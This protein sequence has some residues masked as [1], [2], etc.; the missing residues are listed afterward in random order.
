MT[1]DDQPNDLEVKTALCLSGGG[2]RSAA[3][4]IGVLQGL[5]GSG[6]K[7]GEEFR[8]L[9]TVSGGGF[10]GAW[11][12][13]KQPR[14]KKSFDDA[15]GELRG[16]VA[17]LDEAPSLKRWHL[18]R[19]RLTG[20]LGIGSA[21][22]AKLLVFWLFAIP[23]LWTVLLVLEQI[24]ELIDPVA[25]AAAQLPNWSWLATAVLAIAVLQVELLRTVAVRVGL[26]VA[27]IAAVHY[28][29]SF[30]AERIQ[31]ELLALGVALGGG[32]VALGRSA[33]VAQLRWV[34]KGIGT[35]RLLGAIA[36]ASLALVVVVAALALVACRERLSSIADALP[37]VREV[38]EPWSIAI[39]TAIPVVAL[40]VVR[41]E[42]FL[43]ARTYQERIRAG[44][45]LGHSRLPSLSQR[46][47]L[48]LVRGLLESI[49]PSWIKTRV[50]SEPVTDTEGVPKPTLLV[51]TAWSI[52]EKAERQWDERKARSFVWAFHRR[53]EPGCYESRGRE[54]VRRGRP[55]VDIAVAVATSAGVV[56]PRMGSYTIRPLGLLFSMFNVRLGRWFKAPDFGSPTG[57]LGGLVL[58]ELF[59]GWFR[60]QPDPKDLE[61]SDRNKAASARRWM[62]LT[63]GG[64]FDNLGLY[65]AVK[66]KCTHVIV[67]DGGR[68]PKYRF[69]ELANALRKIRIDHEQTE[70]DIDGLRWTEAGVEQTGHRRQRIYGGTIRY[71]GKT[72]FG[73]IVYIKAALEGDEPADV[74]GYAD[75]HPAFPHE[76][77]SD[78]W[79]S[80]SQFESYR[81]LGAYTVE[82]ALEHYAAAK[83]V[84]PLPKE[85]T[86]T[87]AKAVVERLREAAMIAGR[88]DLRPTHGGAIVYR[89]QDNTNKLEFLF[90]EA[91]GRGSWV[92]PKGHIEC[93]E[94]PFQCARRELEEEAE[95]RWDDRPKALPRALVYDKFKRGSDEEVRC[96]YHLVDLRLLRRRKQ[97]NGEAWESAE[98]GRTAAEVTSATASRPESSSDRAAREE[99]GQLWITAEDYKDVLEEFERRL[100][101]PNSAFK[102]S[103]EEPEEH[104]DASW[105]PE[106]K[107]PPDDPEAIATL[108]TAREPIEGLVWVLQEAKR[109]VE[110][111]EQQ[112]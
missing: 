75:L 32:V 37:L 103:K 35:M 2:V 8:Y 16:T 14:D 98:D 91:L 79:F 105:E 9:S 19:W 11:Y 42:Y 39:L 52:D 3:F 81:R 13:T 111:A 26:L 88:A 4:S 68:D 110:L 107:R 85:E 50:E 65:E 92:L 66:R 112:F 61:G 83:L 55:T 15:L 108:L 99:R 10:A 70:I 80:E 21:F 59:P 33:Q 67:V 96:L 56:G 5:R 47:S 100:K 51:N 109:R 95:L 17:Y 60:P 62:H 20:A 45:K 71:P 12:W 57:S 77:T 63:D 18:D 74:A 40:G 93:G 82:A 90:V 58:E 84:P 101:N 29:M 106:G 36:W 27:A 25:G 46:A 89:R 24:G 64:H 41:A 86:R 48:W 22:F 102:E 31:A 97:N 78:Q 49:C 76:S 28:L 104:D 87:G 34:A 69:S 6:L 7:D 54:R 43:P 53:D 94:S 30:E 1:N 44:F 73:R 72:T 38:P 23:A